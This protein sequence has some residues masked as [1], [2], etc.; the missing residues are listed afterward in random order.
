MAFAG[1]LAVRKSFR[2]LPFG[3]AQ[4]WLRGHIWIG[5]VSVP[6]VLFHANFR[7]GGV[8]EMALMAVFFI[9]IASG[10]FGLA[11]QQVLPRFLKVRVPLETFPQQIPSLLKK[12]RDEAEELLKSLSVPAKAASAVGAPAAAGGAPTSAQSKLELLKSAASA[13]AA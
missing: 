1:L 2:V 11:L 9:V 3:S 6:L 10:V 5:L 12:S 4:F 7:L 13:K 8:L